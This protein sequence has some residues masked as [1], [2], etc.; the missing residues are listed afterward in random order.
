MFVVWPTCL[1]LEKKTEGVRTET[2]VKDEHKNS[3]SE[4]KKHAG[5]EGGC[6]AIHFLIVNFNQAWARPGIQNTKTP[7]SSPHTHTHTHRLLFPTLLISTEQVST[8]TQQRV[9]GQMGCRVGWTGVWMW[10]HLDE[11]PDIIR[12]QSY[13]TSGMRNKA[14]NAGLVS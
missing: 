8:A 9:R 7:H 13:T 14:L 1:A 2:E 11:W 10:V 3:V 4:K 5:R 6:M 12:H